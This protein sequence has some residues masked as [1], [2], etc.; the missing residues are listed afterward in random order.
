MW[1]LVSSDEAQGTERRR[2]EKR[3]RERERESERA[4]KG[5]P[6]RSFHGEKKVTRDLVGGR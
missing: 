3:E 1:P 2:R 5:P 6:W 4:R